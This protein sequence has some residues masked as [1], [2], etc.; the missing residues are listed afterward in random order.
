MNIPVP[1]LGYWSK[2]KAGIK[3]ERP[4]LPKYNGPE[5]SDVY[6]SA[7]S[8]NI[9]EIA[10]YFIS[11]KRIC[12]NYDEERKLEQLKSEAL[13]WQLAMTIRDYI[14]AVEKRVL[15]MK[16]TKIEKIKIRN[17]LRWAKQKA[18][19]LDPITAY[20]DYLLYKKRYKRIFFDD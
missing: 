3:I 1:G 6:D 10:D 2:I 20:K 13:D 9:S 8:S 11:L 5:L 12:S 15:L 17:R 14:C 16:L 7:E 4:K 18:D 19:W